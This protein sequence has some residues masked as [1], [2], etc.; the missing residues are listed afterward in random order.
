[1]P[2]SVRT[3]SSLRSLHDALPIS[4][5]RRRRP[6]PSPAG[7]V[8]GGARSI[9]SSTPRGASS[10][11]TTCSSGASRVRRS[12]PWAPSSSCARCGSRRRSEEHT[13]ELQ[14][15]RHLVCR[16][17][18]ARRPR[19]V[20]YTTLFRSRGGGDGDRR[21]APRA[22][23]G[24]A[25]VRSLPPRRG[26]QARARPRALPGHPGYGDRS[27]GRR[28]R[29][30]LGADRGEDR[31]STRLNSSHLGIS[32]AVF[33]AHAV[34]APFPTRRS[35]DLVGAE[36]ATAAEPRGRRSGG[37]PFDHFLHAEGGKLELDHVLFRGI[38]G[39]AIG[40]LGAELELRSVRIAE[41]I[42]RA[43]V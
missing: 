22:A 28:A 14:S 26:G 32:Y 20:P 38:Q 21:R 42:G 34:L 11:S 9:T 1:M 30:A 31:K 40:A 3:P 7:G 35:S 5:G 19:S 23:F 10:S 18:C 4:W 29:A 16:L 24:G 36:T 13:S 33:C 17:L 15:L 25:P 2:S 12:E 27:P 43:H 37:R 41:K 8:R 6:P 39:T